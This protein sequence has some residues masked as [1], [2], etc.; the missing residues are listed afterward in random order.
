[1]TIVHKSGNIHKNADGLSRWALPNTSDNPAYA[2][3]STE[4]QISIQG[5][6]ITSVG[7]EFF[8]EVRESNKQDNNCHILTD[9]LDKDCK[10]ASL[11]N[12]LDD[13]WKKRMTMEDSICLIN[14]I[15]DR[16]AKFK[17]ALWTNLHKILGTKRSFSAAYHP[18]TDGLAERMIQTLEDMIRRFCAYG[19][20]LKY[21]DG[22]THDRCTLIP[23]LERAYKTSIHA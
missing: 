10:N 4:A 16:D 8:E 15:S 14:I 19:L 5:I 3:T 1:M 13:I 20:E 17:S 9:L 21:L 7:T 12:S 23:A 6:S 2:P 22:F 11:A 18:Q